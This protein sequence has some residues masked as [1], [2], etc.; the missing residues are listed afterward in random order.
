MLPL[1]RSCTPSRTTFPPPEAAFTICELSLTVVDPRSPTAGF[2]AELFLLHEDLL[3]I[4][5]TD[6]FGGVCSNHGIR[7]RRPG[8]ACDFFCRA[9]GRVQPRFARGGWSPSPAPRFAF[10]RGE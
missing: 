5:V 10:R 3:A 9:I 7:T 2:T 6:V 8:L 1:A 4:G